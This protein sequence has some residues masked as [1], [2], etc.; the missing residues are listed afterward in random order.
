MA[1]LPPSARPRARWMFARRLLSA[2]GCA[3]ND[4]SHLELKSFTSA[5]GTATLS[6]PRAEGPG[7]SRSTRVRSSA[8]SRFARTQPA[9]PPPTIT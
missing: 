4:Q 1:L 5:T 2:R 8:L 7:S 3:L 6:A 9:V